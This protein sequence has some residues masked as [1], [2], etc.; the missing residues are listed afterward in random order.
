MV[1]LTIHSLTHDSI[2]ANIT[3][4]E[5]YVTSTF[6]FL[7]KKQEYNFIELSSKKMSSPKKFAHNLFIRI[8][9]LITSMLLTFFIFFSDIKIIFPDMLK[10]KITC[11][12]ELSDIS[13]MKFSFFIII[14]V[15]IWAQCL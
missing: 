6:I 10:A 3:I 11:S 15:N 9:K 5:F 12:H 13:L 14:R 7:G 4:V 2:H 8:F 1:N